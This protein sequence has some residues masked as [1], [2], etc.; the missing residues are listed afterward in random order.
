MTTIDPTTAGGGTPE[1][2]LDHRAC[3]EA[4]R[5]RDARFDGRFYTA[6]T[7]TGIFCRPSC[8]ARTPRAT[9]VRFFSHAAAASDA[10][11]RPCRRCRPELAP[12]HPEWNRRADL[13]G[14]AM[15][16]IEQGVVDRE[17]VSG[18]ATRLAVSERHL[19]R[20]LTAVVGAGPVQLAKTRRLWLAR[21]LLD[22]TNLA[23]TDVAFASGFSSVRQFN[24]AFR[25]AFDATP[26]SLRRRPDT[27]ARGATELTLALS[28][29]GPVRWGDL[30]R[31]LSMPGGDPGLGGDEGVPPRGARRSGRAG[32][33]ARRPAPR[34]A[35]F[36][37]PARPGRRAGSPDPPPHRSRHRP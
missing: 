29:R 2:A 36:P 24:E 32:R 13:A 35:V 30:H 20:E 1:P 23:V 28:G 27:A 31:F 12:G 33:L 34:P 10:G 21:M 16:L 15:A 11:F 25:H 7:T 5:R 37:R 18:L 26:S 14:R 8:P 4:V 17:G 6:V 9:N 19:R 22:Q 3:Y